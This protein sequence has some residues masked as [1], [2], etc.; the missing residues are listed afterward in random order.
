M[1]TDLLAVIE[2]RAHRSPVKT[3]QES[4]KLAAPRVVAGQL[5]RRFDTFGCLSWS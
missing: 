5:N 4:D 2:N 3:T 1:I